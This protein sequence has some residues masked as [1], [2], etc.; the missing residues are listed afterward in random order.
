[1]PTPSAGL[2]IGL[3][4]PHL[5]R[6]GGIR[7]MLEFSNRLVDR[8]HNV[9]FYLPDD[10]ELSCSWM[11]CRAS[12]KPIRE[13]FDDALDIVCF[14]H[15]PQWHLV[16][17]F[18]N[19]RRRIFYAL[20]Y[21][22]VYEKEGSWESVRAPVDLQLANSNWTADQIEAETGYRPTVV[23]GGV[24]RET[25]RPWDVSKRYKV[26]CTGD[27]RRPW[28]GTDTV[29][30]ACR[31]LGITP[32][33]YSGKNLDQVALGR[34]YAAAE[35]FA[36]GSWFEGFG[37]PGLEAL[38]CGVP[39]V[40]TDNGGCREYAID[41]ETALIVPPRD[42]DAMSDAIARM[43]GDRELA[44]RLSRNG[45]SLVDDE[46]S[47]E[48]RTDELEVIL[49]GLSAGVDIAPVPT[50]PDPPADPVL[51]VVTL[52]WNGLL[53]TQ[54]F[55]ESVR[56][57]TDVPY[58]LIIVDNGSDW[59]AASYAMAA[60]DEGIANAANRGFAMG[61]NQ[62]L[63][64]AKGRHVAFCNNDT[65]LP[66]GWASG[67]LETARAHPQAGIVVPAVTAARNPHTVRTE[68]GTEVEVLPPYSAPPAAVIYLCEADT[69]R[70]LGGWGEEYE[71]ASGE[72]VDLAFKVW[73]N[74]LDIVYDQ[75]ILVQHEGKGAASRL[76]DWR[77]LW[78]QNRR[79]FLDKWSGDGAV[80]RLDGV[81]P[82]RFE[83]NRATA[84]AAAQWMD[85]FFSARS[86]GRFALFGG[87][88][89]ADPDRTVDRLRPLWRRVKPLLPGRLAASASRR[90]KHRLRTRDGAA[91]PAADTA[92]EAGEAGEATE[93]V[94]DPARLAELP[95]APAGRP[96]RIFMVREGVAVH[97][98]EGETR[99]SV[100]SGLLAAALE[101]RFGKPRIVTAADLER[102]TEG[103]PVAIFAASSG[104][105]MIIVGGQLLPVK[106][107]PVPQPIDVGLTER[108]PR[109]AVLDVAGANVPRARWEEARQ[110]RSLTIRLARAAVRAVRP[111]QGKEA[112]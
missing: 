110:K 56:R 75:R 20:H 17:R 106:G 4:E 19:A 52:Q 59:E 15:E 33:G 48:R 53:D 14:N 40:T 85:R 76:P 38:A 98:I 93:P 61:M 7:R 71:I 82:A 27:D 58:E 103:P 86:D 37:Q 72:D 73:V 29:D 47:W 43:L 92:A 26:L 83:R 16:E 22:R 100:K 108:F 3:I 95:A 45:L 109:G 64:V 10:V 13:G 96:G 74:D 80:P 2:T 94:A 39:L 41:G 81:D 97:L 70:A 5:R 99:R 1:M 88:P 35:V 8:G 65:V 11:E 51:S 34:E 25:F 9:V 79:R 67:L 60:A 46:F 55:V 69:I 49:D 28:K 42:A 32:E 30:A 87:G 12:I 57:N 24:N 54:Q 77:A 23:L 107:L 36:V 66:P 104:L 68:P 18:R 84:R 44:R 101:D 78:E 105:P 90:A 63:A 50:R 111:R 91:G 102:W 112:G 21:S 6:Y 31:R 62:G 89:A